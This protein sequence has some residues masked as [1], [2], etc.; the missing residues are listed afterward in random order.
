L[1]FQ[2]LTEDTV[3]IALLLDEPNL[4]PYQDRLI[5]VMDMRKAVSTNLETRLLSEK[6]L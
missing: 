4:D 6:R 3:R 1:I 2:S 5:L